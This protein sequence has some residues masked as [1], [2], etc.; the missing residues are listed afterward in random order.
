MHQSL[1]RGEES[2]ISRPS[3]DL[4]A[5]EVPSKAKS[6]RDALL[7]IGRA[8]DGWVSKQTDSTEPGPGLEALE[9]ESTEAQAQSTRRTAARAGNSC[10]IQR[11]CWFEQQK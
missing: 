3:Q 9:H 4:S 7:A 1:T 6:Q 11:R 5:H 2:A 10:S 8:I